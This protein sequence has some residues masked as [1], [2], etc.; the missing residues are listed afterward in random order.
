LRS[1]CEHLKP[2]GEQSCGEASACRVPEIVI[3][4]RSFSLKFWQ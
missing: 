2:M 3:H 4:R 1:A